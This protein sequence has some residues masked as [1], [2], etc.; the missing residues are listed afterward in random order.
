MN[1]GGLTKILTFTPVTISAGSDGFHTSSAGTGVAIRGKLKMLSDQRKMVYTELVNAE[2]YEFT[3]FDNAAIT[4]NSSV[5]Y[6]TKTLYVHSLMSVGDPSHTAK[7][8]VIL[9]TK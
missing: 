2:V 8:K 9:Y 6:G 3:C 7:K 1:T 5:T 4:K